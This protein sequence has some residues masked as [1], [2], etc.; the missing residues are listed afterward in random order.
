MRSLGGCPE[1]DEIEPIRPV[2]PPSE[3]GVLLGAFLLWL[4]F[5]AV[6]WFVGIYATVRF[7]KWAW[8]D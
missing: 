7:V 1:G 5:V 2:E 4:L 8:V 3:C 6:P